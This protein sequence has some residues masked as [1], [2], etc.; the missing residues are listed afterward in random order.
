MTGL[1]GCNITNV[2]AGSL[3]LHRL[4]PAGGPDIESSGLRNR[5]L[6]NPA[7]RID[8]ADPK[9]QGIGLLKGRQDVV[10]GRRSRSVH[11]ER[12]REKLHVSDPLIQQ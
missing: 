2:E 4:K 11:G 1:I 8:D 7:G 3:P 12:L 6:G 10:P 5:G 9:I